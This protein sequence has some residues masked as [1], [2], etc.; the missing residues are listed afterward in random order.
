MMEI[1]VQPLTE[2]AFAPYGQVI[3]LGPL[4]RAH[5]T[6]YAADVENRRAEAKLNV[7][8]SQQIP[9]PLPLVVKAM[10]MHPHS[11]QTFVPTT[12]ERYLILVCPKA[13]NG[14]PDIDNLKAFVADGGQGINY[15]ADTWH[16]P[17]TALDGPAE[18]VVL[19][20]DMDD[21]EDTLWFVVDDGPT[22]VDA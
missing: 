22:I 1:T 2:D 13:D 10:E 4:G 11:A 6:R 8:I 17:F 16:H 20:Y 14:D 5:S 19:R 12:A 21:D 15:H 9:T 3:A 7:S 18:C